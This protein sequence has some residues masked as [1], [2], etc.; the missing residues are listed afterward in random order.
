MRKRPIPWNNPNIEQPAILPDGAHRSGLMKDFG[1]RY[2]PAHQVPV[3]I[4]GIWLLRE[5]KHVIVLVECDGR[6]VQVIREPADAPFS[7]IV[8]A[9]GIRSRCD[10][11]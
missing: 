2:N 11:V 6:W 3:V 8:E 5:E 4:S 7:H 9:N 1:G 10:N